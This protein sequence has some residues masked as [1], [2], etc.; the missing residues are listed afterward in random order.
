MGAISFVVRFV[1]SHQNNDFASSDGTYELSYSGY[2]SEPEESLPAPHMMPA[3]TQVDLLLEAEDAMF[4]AAHAPAPGPASSFTRIDEAAV[5]QGF[6]S[7]AFGAT[8]EEWSIPGKRDI[9]GERALLEA[10]GYAEMNGM[11][12]DFD[13]AMS[14][15][16]GAQPQM[17]MFIHSCIEAGCEKSTAEFDKILESVSYNEEVAT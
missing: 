16:D 2:W 10:A 12:A 1:V 3:G 14:V 8:L 13:V 9:A 6:E 5:R 4:I 15:T 11:R 17:V 7:A